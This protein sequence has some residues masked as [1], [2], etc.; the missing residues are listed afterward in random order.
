M[1]ENEV[2]NWIPYR[3]D[4]DESELICDWLY[5]N[6]KKFVEPFFEETTTK[7]KVF[8]ENRKNFKSKSTLDG[9]IHFSEKIAYLAPKAFIFHVSRCGSTLLAQLLSLDEQNIVLSE[10]PILD[11]VIREITFKKPEISD[12]K[13]DEVILAI[14]KILGQKRSENDK[15]LFVKLDSWHIL[16]YEKLRKLFPD[17]PFLF[18]FRQPDQV[19]KSQLKLPGM[20]AMPGVIQPELFGFNFTEIIAIPRQEYIV[21]V[22]EK[23]FENL[24]EIKKNDNNTLFL[25][26]ISGN[27]INLDKIESFLG[28]SFESSIKNKMIERMKFHSKEPNTIFEEIQVEVS[29]PDYQKRVF[30]LYNSLKT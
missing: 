17:T 12:Q 8:E 22:L 30:E 21:K 26:Y 4:F 15:N 14:V 3:L 1:P 29:I 11:E 16:F 20:H 28:L 9:M 7:C 18:S 2:V 6:D 19:I 10:P 24:L 23:Y 25:D 13:I 5:L 27:L